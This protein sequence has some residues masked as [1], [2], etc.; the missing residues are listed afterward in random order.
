MFMHLTNYAINYKNKNFEFNTDINDSNHGHKRTFSSILE[1]I[2]SN[3][4]DG[5]S[6][7]E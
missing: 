4:E 5:A 3:F 1:F 2:R 7:V 6:K